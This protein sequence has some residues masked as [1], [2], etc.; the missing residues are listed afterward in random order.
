MDQRNFININF[1]N[2]IKAKLI[3]VLLKGGIRIAYGNDEYDYHYFGQSASQLRLKVCV[4]YNYTILGDYNQLIAKFGDFLKIKN[5]AKRSARIGLLLSTYEKMF[6]LDEKN[7]EYTDDVKN[8][9]FNFTDGCG[10]ISSNYLV[11]IAKRKNLSQFYSHYRAYTGPSVIQIRLNGCKGV[12]SACINTENKVILRP[13]LKKFEWVREPPYSLGIVDDGISHPYTYAYLN[14]Q[15]ICILSA[16]GIS[17]DVFLKKQAKYFHEMDN[18]LSNMEYTLRYLYFWQRYDLAERLMKKKVIDAETRSFLAGKRQSLTISQV[19]KENNLLSTKTKPSNAEGLKIPIENSRNVF[20]IGDPSGKIDVDRCFFQPTIDGKT[21]IFH[22]IDIVVLKSPCYHPG[23][24]KV[25]K[26]VDIPECRHL[27][28]CLIFSTNGSRPAPDQIAGSDLDGDKYFVCWDTDLIPLSTKTPTSYSGAK[29]KDSDVTYEQLI[30]YFSN[31][32]ASL[33]GTVNNYWCKWADYA[34]VNS[35]QCIMLANL[36]SRAVDAAK[37]GENIQLPIE[38][39]EIPDKK[40]DSKRYVWEQ[41]VSNAKSFLLKSIGDHEFLQLISDDELISLLK[42]ENLRIDDF[43]LFRTIYQYMFNPKTN[44][45][46]VFYKLIDYICFDYFTKDQIKLLRFDC[47]EL[48]EDYLIN[49]LY[50]S[51]F[52]PKGFARYLQENQ[53]LNWS[54][55]YSAKTNEEIN[56][57]VINN[58]MQQNCNKLLIFEFSMGGDMKRIIAIAV[59]YALKLNEFVTHDVKLNASVYMSIGNGCKTYRS[60]ITDEFTWSLEDDRLQ[61]FIGNQQRTFVCFMQDI[62]NKENKNVMS[63]ALDFFDRKLLRE[64]PKLRRDVILSAEFY[65]DMGVIQQF[66]NRPYFNNDYLKTDS[67]ETVASNRVDFNYNEEKFPVLNHINAYENQLKCKRDFY[68]EIRRE[69]A[70]KLNR[71]EPVQEKMVQLLELVDRNLYLTYEILNYLIHLLSRGSYFNDLHDYMTLIKSLIYM[72][73][74]LFNSTQSMLEKWFISFDNMRRFKKLLDF[75]DIE[76]IFNTII[77]CQSCRGEFAFEL[78][79]LFKIG[80]LPMLDTLKPIKCLYFCYWSSLLTIELI[81]EIEDY[82]S[83]SKQMFEIATGDV[84]KCTEKYGEQIT[85]KINIRD[86]TVNFISTDFMA[87]TPLYDANS[88]EFNYNPQFF[89]QIIKQMGQIYQIIP[90]WPLDKEIDAKIVCRVDKFPS[91]V[92]Y[93]RQ[94]DALK[95]NCS[96][97]FNNHLNEF[98]ISNF[99]NP[100]QP[101]LKSV[102]QIIHADNNMNLIY[103]KNGNDEQKHAIYLCNKNAISLIHGP[104]GIVI[105]IVLTSLISINSCNSFTCDLIKVLE[106]QRLHAK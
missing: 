25:L 58:F 59:N 41:M 48:N 65:S 73:P 23:D 69:I 50:R 31:Y 18:L 84:F 39:K 40:S 34:G 26:C 96:L 74:K 9:D 14:K 76:D 101:G 86:A 80:Y 55:Y 49:S 33:V 8:A 20:G 21:K 13:S 51:H 82:E 2:K 36:F 29:S 60:I 72:T 85:W 5:V 68:E 79:S 43:R 77:F 42:N 38:L 24:I 105:I 67:N 44:K 106:K 75:S 32:N 81:N 53:N 7:I 27:Y 28:D 102:D 37:S 3:E 97:D 63:V 12:L 93:K 71:N 87:L 95:N 17:D 45:K 56:W 46:H 6:E 61:V 91:L 64:I 15:F 70:E 100:N 104:P 99:H 47:S 83:K 57:H 10:F 103:L 88:D 66:Y 54:L 52:M 90:I 22:D 78:L 62:K 89:Y 98:I 92:T 4:L 11:E 19:K 94:I 16:N 30:K 35:A 1:D